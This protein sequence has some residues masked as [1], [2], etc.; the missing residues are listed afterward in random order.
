METV[1]L[2]ERFASKVDFDGDGGCWLWLASTQPHNGYGR[3]WDGSRTVMAHRWSYEAHGRVIPRGMQ[4]DHLC[5]VR[6]C[7]NPDHLEPVTNDENTR[8]AAGGIQDLTV[9]RNGHPRTPE[10]TYTI[11][12]KRNGHPVSYR[13]CRLCHIASAQARPRKRRAA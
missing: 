5:R 13:R 11:R 3:Y 2:P 10:N 6:A 4:L 12:T 7:V 1:A 8:R 9:C